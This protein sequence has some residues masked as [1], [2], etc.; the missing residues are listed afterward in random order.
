MNVFDLLN[1]QIKDKLVDFGFHEPTPPQI[2]AIPK[3]LK[4]FNTLIVTPTGSGKTEAAMFP[5]LS[6]ILDEKIKG[7]YKPGIKAL[8]IT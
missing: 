1:K 2:K 6:N 8:Y 4:G 3:I 5:I 7:E